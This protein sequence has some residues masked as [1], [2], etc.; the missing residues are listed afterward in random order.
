MSTAARPRTVGSRCSGRRNG[1]GERFHIPEVRSATSAL[2]SSS[3]AQ[4]ARRPQRPRRS[5]CGK[6]A[7]RSMRGPRPVP[8]LER[9]PELC[10]HVHGT[11]DRTQRGRY[12][13]SRDAWHVS[14]RLGIRRTQ[15]ERATHVI[16]E[17]L[18]LI[19]CLVRAGG[20]ELPGSVRGH[21]QERNLGRSAS[22]MVKKVGTRAAGGAEH[23][24]RSPCLASATNA[25]PFVDHHRVWMPRPGQRER[26]EWSASRD[27][28]RHVARRHSRD[29]LQ[30][31]VREPC[32]P[33]PLRGH[34]TVREAS[35][36]F[37]GLAGIRST[38]DAAA[39]TRRPR[40]SGTAPSG[41]PPRTFRALLRPANRTVRRMVRVPRARA[42]PERPALDREACL[43]R[44][45]S[46]ATL[47]R[48]RAR[49][50]P[51]AEAR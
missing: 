30:R 40:A 2:R 48:C 36:R 49:G 43:P 38:N 17:Q 21:A 4:R 42:R 37:P 46:D 28:R 32:V 33:S 27:T 7:G 41:S 26:R 39:R 35:S 31:G 8:G 47:P 45:A 9:F 19:E 3:H 20:R 44:P 13:V 18:L 25:G 1:S 29:R 34:R 6:D 14:E 16:A 22:R 5:P 24:G 11:G 12:R 23:E 51:Q 15:L 50:G 10:V